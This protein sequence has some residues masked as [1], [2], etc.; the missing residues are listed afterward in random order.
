MHQL[1]DGRRRY[2]V[3]HTEAQAQ[4]EQLHVNIG[5]LHDAAGISIWTRYYMRKFNDIPA[6]KLPMASQHGTDIG[7]QL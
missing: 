4:P 7:K 3:Q 1:V 5:I 2:Q 6:R